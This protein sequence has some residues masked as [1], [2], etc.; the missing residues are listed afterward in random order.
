MERGHQR[1]GNGVGILIDT[2]V[3]LD[4]YHPTNDDL[5]ELEKRTVLLQ[6]NRLPFWLSEQ[7]GEED[8]KADRTIRKL[9]ASTQHCRR[10]NYSFWATLPITVTWRWYGISTDLG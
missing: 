3:L 5:K 8:L 2:N 10:V 1:R 4:F 7:V 6:K 9:F